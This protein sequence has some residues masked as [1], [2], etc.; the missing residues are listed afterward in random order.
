M[1]SAS[2]KT[3]K[4]RVTAGNPLEPWAIFIGTPKGKNH[5]FR[6]LES[7]ENSEKFCKD[8]E[9]NKDIEGEEIAWQ[10]FEEKHNIHADISQVE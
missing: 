10:D 5:F 4:S 1:S 2:A 9:R 7:A 3:S 8:Y 6:R